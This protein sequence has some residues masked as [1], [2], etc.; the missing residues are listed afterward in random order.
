MSE[1]TA[2]SPCRAE[3]LRY[4]NVT[5]LRKRVRQELEQFF[6][7]ASAMSDK[8]V[9]VDGWKGPKAARQ[10]IEEAAARYVRRGLD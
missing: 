8:K 4:K 5:E 9:V 6:I 3:D 2:S 10:V 7:T 1:T